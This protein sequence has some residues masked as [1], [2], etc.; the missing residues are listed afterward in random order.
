MST[1]SAKSAPEPSAHLRGIP[2][3]QALEIRRLAHELSN[4][5]EIIVQ[6]NYLLSMAQLK[7]P[8][9]EWLHM[10]ESGV[11]KALETNQQLREYIK[12]NTEN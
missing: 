8:A 12:Q 5:L 2:E 6:T 3:E 11:K 9:A 7:E 10:L 1:P 4:A